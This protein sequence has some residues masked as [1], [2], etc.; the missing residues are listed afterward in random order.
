[1]PANDYHFVTHWRVRSTPEEAA[2]VISD[3]TGLP[4]W[5]PAVYLD[6][7]ER[8]RG[9]EDG[10]GRVIDL[11]T[12]G[13]LPYTLRWN[14]TVTESDYPHTLAIV[15]EGD[16]NGTGRWMFVGDGDFTDV[17]YDWRISANKPL[18][19]RL[20]WAMKPVFAANHRWAMARG[21]E[22]LE[23]ELERRRAE[24]PEEA[25]AFPPPPRAT[26]TRDVLKL[27]VPAAI[28]G[29]AFAIAAACHRRYHRGWWPRRW[30]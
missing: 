21:L 5:W 7:E 24:S 6:V 27:A 10:V 20:S 11:Y 28:A 17:T 23:L 16:F 13:W 18:L 3:A 4:R 26:A 1:M 14:F 22:S 19:R 30:F 29:A 15:A 8:E 25:A 12:K 9:D 2:D